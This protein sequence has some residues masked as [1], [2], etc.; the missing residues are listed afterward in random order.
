MKGLR[1]AVIG[2]GRVGCGFDDYSNGKIIRTHAGSYFKNCNTKLVALCDVDKNKLQ[3]YGKKYKVK[4][5][6]TESSEMFENEHIDCVSICTLVDTHLRLVEKAA[7]YG[8]RGIFLE[9]PI[10]NSLQSARKIIDICKAH[11]IVLLIDHQR[12]FDPFY[13]YLKKFILNNKLGK[14]QLVNIYYGRG[15]ANSGSHLFDMLHLLFGEIISIKANFSNFKPIY[16]H[17]PDIDAD[18][19]IRNKIICRMKCLDARNYPLLEMDILGTRG[20]IRL[21]FVTNDVEYFKISSKNILDFKSLM[22]T[23]MVVSSP[24]FS[25]IPLGVKNMVS[26]I[27]TKKRPLCT[28]EDGYKSLE[29]IIASIQSSKQNRKIYLPLKRNSYKISSK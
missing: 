18:I 13:Q 19:E 15:I 7:K 23:K 14:I 8:V 29:L 11:K 21:N 17:D 1:C 16:K 10:S 25:T 3:K 24:T 9:K 22:K 20:R 27:R 2:C 26:C 28:G 4:G 6:Y 5:L 12:R